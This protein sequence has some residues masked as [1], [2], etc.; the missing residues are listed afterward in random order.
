M[1]WIVV[2]E[3]M[4]HIQRSESYSSGP[5]PAIP[6][7]VLHGKAPHASR[8]LCDL[9]VEALHGW[10]HLSFPRAYGTHC[11]ACVSTIEVM[12]AADPLVDRTAPAPA[13][14]ARSA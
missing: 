9:E 5:G 11:P 1:R 6:A 4:R 12:P 10:A 2:S 3:K 8:T 7:G 14:S 13:R